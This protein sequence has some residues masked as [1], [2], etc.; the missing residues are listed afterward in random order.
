MGVD[1]ENKDIKDSGNDVRKINN[2]SMVKSAS[3]IKLQRY[4]SVKVVGKNKNTIN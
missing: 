4:G 1:G 3:P 2:N